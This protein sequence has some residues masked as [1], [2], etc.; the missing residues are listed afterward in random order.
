[1]ADV[2][3]EI[4]TARSGDVGALVRLSSALF[5]EDAGERD[6]FVDLGWPAAHGRDHFLSLITQNGA[7]CL[8]AKYGRTAVGYLAGYV[9]KITEI[10]PLRVAEIQS[11]HVEVGSRN[12]GVRSAMV[13]EFLSWA[14]DRTAERVSVTAYA[15]N[16]AA[17]GFY[18]CRGFRPLSATLEMPLE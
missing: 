12:R 3:Y 6:S 10:R 2:D 18:A 17:L 16:D 1:M 7:L 13:D 9:R 14:G 5:R 15:L 8:L 11:T 4:V